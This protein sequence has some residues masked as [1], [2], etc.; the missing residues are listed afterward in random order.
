MDVRTNSEI[1]LLLQEWADPQSLILLNRYGGLAPW[2][3]SRLTL[4]PDRT[5]KAME[6]AFLGERRKDQAA[7]DQI[8]DLAYGLMAGGPHRLRSLQELER[9]GR[10]QLVMPMLAILLHHDPDMN[11]RHTILAALATCARTQPKAR[12]I[13]DYN[14][15]SQE[16]PIQLRQEAARYARRLTLGLDPLTPE[17]GMD[18]LSKLSQAV[19]TDAQTPATAL[20]AQAQAALEAPARSISER[21]R[22]EAIRASRDELQAALA[23]GDQDAIALAL[24]RL[25]AQL[26][27]AQGT[28]APG[29][30]A[31]PTASGWSRFAHKARLRLT[32]PSMVSVPGLALI[33][34]LELKFLALLLPNPFAMLAISLGLLAITLFV[35]HPRADRHWA[36]RFG[37]PILSHMSASALLFNLCA[38]LLLAGGA[39]LTLPICIFGTFFIMLRTVPKLNEAFDHTLKWLEPSL[40]AKISAM[41][42]DYPPELRPWIDGLAGSGQMRRRTIAEMLS[43]PKISR[44]LM[45]VVRAL[46]DKGDPETSA[47]FIQLLG[48]WEDAESLRQLE[49]IAEKG[50]PW[51][52]T[53]PYSGWAAKILDDLQI[54]KT[55]LAETRN[56]ADLTRSAASADLATALLAKAQTAMEQVPQSL[57][58]RLRQKALRDSRDGLQAALAAGDQD[59]IALALSRLQAQLDGGMRK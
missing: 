57:S 54:Q 32:R 48:R 37:L 39:P 38:F 36:Y 22:Q 47:A 13:I 4:L 40:Q 28:L 19:G 55:A 26:D 44:P 24:N 14:A 33:S 16:L 11:L 10:I 50:K 5:I 49:D 6:L 30:N 27:G 31:L 51:W 18:H 15:H 43:D 1:L 56:L 53:G 46:F 41:R 7:L 12:T 25:Q 52:Q 2:T 45:P 17:V 42:W 23:A 29:S 59:A 9:Q 20:L 58:E 8:H 35:V 21:L 34:A 3:A